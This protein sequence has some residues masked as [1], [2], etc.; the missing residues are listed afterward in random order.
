MVVCPHCG[1][2][3]DVS[4]RPPRPRVPWWKY[5]PGPTANLGCGTLILIALV[6]AMFSSG[7]KESLARLQQDVRALQEKIDGLGRGIEK[8]LPPAQRGDPQDR[9]P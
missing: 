1:E 7:N 9:A 4:P 8:L 3:L 6:V 2:E 5:D